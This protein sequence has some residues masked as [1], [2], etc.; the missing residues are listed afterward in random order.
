MTPG[1]SGDRAD[2]ITVSVSHRTELFADHAD[3]FVVVK[4]TSLVTGN[5]AL[6]KAREVRQLVADL[7]AEGLAE[8]NVFLQGVFTEVS[9]GVLTKSSEARYRLRIHVARLDALADVLGVIAAQKNTRLGHIRWGYAEDDAVRD[10][11][12]STCI[13]RAGAK[14]RLIAD[15][16]GVTLLGVHRFSERYADPEQG[17]PSETDF[18]GDMDEARVKRR[19]GTEDLGLAVSH[20]KEV[21]LRVEVEYTI[22]GFAGGT[23]PGGDRTDPVESARQ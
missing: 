18:F 8:E 9:S 21:E 23:G 14:A 13:E 12:L 1:A 20:S 3:L 16:L 22:S 2:T 11:W 5:A 4:G 15:G 10:A 7:G 17:R 19:M 6:T